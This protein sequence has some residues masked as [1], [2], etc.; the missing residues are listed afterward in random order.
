[1]DHRSRLFDSHNKKLTAALFFGN[2]LAGTVPPPGNSVV[3]HKADGCP[4][5]PILEEVK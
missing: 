5:G 1:M 2:P 4:G 3:I